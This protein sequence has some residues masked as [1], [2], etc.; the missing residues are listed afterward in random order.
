[1][2]N[3][4]DINEKL[5]N[6]T[7]NII[8][9]TPTMIYNFSIGVSSH[10]STYLKT[11]R[12]KKNAKNSSKHNRG[13]DRKKRQR[14]VPESLENGF[15]LPVYNFNKPKTLLIKCPYPYLESLLLTTKTDIVS[16]HYLI[17]KYHHQRNSWILNQTLEQIEF[18]DSLSKV[19]KIPCIFLEYCKFIKKYVIKETKVKYQMRRL[20]NAWLYKKYSG[21][22][23]NTE[24]VV[25][26]MKPEIPIQIFYSNM[27]GSYIFERST[28]IRTFNDSLKIN[29]YMFPMPQMPKNP[30]TNVEFTKTQVAYIVNKMYL[31]GKT[32]WLIEGF[33]NVRYS[34]P[35]FKMKFMTSLKYE[36]LNE[37]IRSP[38]TYEAREHLIDFLECTL[39]NVNYSTT[40]R[41]LLIWLT[42]NLPNDKF[43][44]EWKKEYVKY[45]KLE[46]TYPM[47]KYDDPIYDKINSNIKKLF[48]M[49][50]E[51]QR[52]AILKLE[53][54]FS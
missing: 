19:M 30:F 2:D 20:L 17:K 32:S 24:D 22:L 39:E 51:F 7:T 13:N 41:M 52:V 14:T 44:L 15:D 3:S 33:S 25:T 6:E 54:A 10:V 26:M 42:K 8:P 35:E 9:P 23:F 36:T 43:L 48:D 47:V 49:N 5:T 16:R 38:E 21:N 46:I 28:L 34:L 27:R 40:K 4:S 37:Y 50:S 18:R 12:D 45:C 11:K 31:H 29:E 1:M 53:Q